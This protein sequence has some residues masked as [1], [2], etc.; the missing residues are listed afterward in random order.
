MTNVKLQLK[1]NTRTILI[2]TNNEETYY[3]NL[4][5]NVPSPHIRSKFHN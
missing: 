2:Q 5:R 1:S 4:Y 3:T